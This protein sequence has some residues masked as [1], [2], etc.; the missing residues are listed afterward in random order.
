MN[1]FYKKLNY[2]SWKNEA[3]R[4][5]LNNDEMRAKL[6]EVMSTRNVVESNTKRADFTEETYKADIHGDYAE[7]Y[8]LE[9]GKYVIYC[10]NVTVCFP[11]G[12]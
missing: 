4:I 1:M 7:L 6:K 5:L 12:I 2:I 10:N 9:N 11:A 3:K 8:M